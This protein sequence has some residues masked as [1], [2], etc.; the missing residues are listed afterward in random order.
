MGEIAPLA[1]QTSSS[2]MGFM[3]NNRLGNGHRLTGDPQFKA[4]ATRAASSTSGRAQ[5]Q[6]SIN[7]N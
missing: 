1:A 7:I 3:V 4:V 5:K 6:I 2:N